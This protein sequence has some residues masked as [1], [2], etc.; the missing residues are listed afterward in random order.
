MANPAFSRKRTSHPLPLPFCLQTGSFG[1]H[2]KLTARPFSNR[3]LSQGTQ[4]TA[5]TD[6]LTT[7]QDDHDDQQLL[8][9]NIRIRNRPYTFNFYNL[10]THSAESYTHV[11]PDAVIICYAID[12]RRTLENAK[13]IW[14]KTVMSQY[15]RQRMDG[16]FA[17]MLLGL[18]RDLRVEQEGV[19]YPQEVS[20]HQ[21]RS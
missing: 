17:V 7:L 20:K 13:Q 2:P 3:R 18:K 8:T 9:F 5:A 1:P 12:D 10:T 15:T 4:K 14:G 21:A 16:D 6:P 11:R 19:I